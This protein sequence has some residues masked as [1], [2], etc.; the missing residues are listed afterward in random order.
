VRNDYHPFRFGQLAK[1]SSLRFK[2]MEEMAAA[3]A[4]R[5]SGDPALA[6]REAFARL[7][8]HEAQ[9]MQDGEFADRMRDQAV[10]NAMRTR[11]ADTGR[12]VFDTSAMILPQATSEGSFPGLPADTLPAFYIQFGERANLALANYDGEYVDGLRTAPRPATKSA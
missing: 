2:R 12:Q 1:T 7:M 4:A 11:W 9:G 8:T 5:R 10:V 3:A 6:N